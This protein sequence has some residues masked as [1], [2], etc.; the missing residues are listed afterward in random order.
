MKLYRDMRAGRCWC[1]RP[2]PP[3]CTH[4]S[5]QGSSGIPNEVCK[6]TNRKAKQNTNKRKHKK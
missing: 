3:H 2:P 6:P 1:L 5:R 4:S